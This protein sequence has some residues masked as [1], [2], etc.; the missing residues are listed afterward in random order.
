MSSGPNKTVAAFRRGRALDKVAEESTNDPRAVTG[1][2]ERVR[3]ANPGATVRTR[4]VRVGPRGGRFRI[5]IIRAYRRP[6]AAEP[7]S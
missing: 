7:Q 4:S 6:P 3:A 1:I 2:E 5:Y